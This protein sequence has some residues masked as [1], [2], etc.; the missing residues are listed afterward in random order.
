MNLLVCLYTC[1][2]IPSISSF[3]LYKTDRSKTSLEYDCLDYY[4]LDTIITYIPIDSLAHQLI[5]Y[6]VRP[7][8]ENELLEIPKMIDM[9]NLTF[10]MLNN[11]SITGE[12]LLAWSASIEL[13]ERYEAFILGKSE[14]DR[15]EVYYNCTSPWFGKHCQYSFWDATMMTEAVDSIFMFKEGER[16]DDVTCYELL[17]VSFNSQ[18]ESS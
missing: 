15:F 4:V 16:P 1:L 12:Q 6:C 13:V 7:S 10:D 3:N 5:A 9:Q 17:S 8:T 11:D 2:L 18:M 14:N